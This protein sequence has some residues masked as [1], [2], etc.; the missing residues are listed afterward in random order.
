MPLTILYVEDNHVVAD[1]V[2]DTLGCEG[3]RVELCADGSEALSLIEGGTHYDLLL[4]DNELPGVSGLEL[5]RRARQLPH[6]RATPIIIISGGDAEAQARGAGADAFLRKPQDVG[7]LV[8]TIARLL[9]R[10]A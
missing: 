4:L 6:R 5:A 7:L 10:G 8:E 3:W 1:T 9:D 2:R